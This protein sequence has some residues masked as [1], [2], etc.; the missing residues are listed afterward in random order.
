MVHIQIFGF[1]RFWG[2][3]VPSHEHIVISKIGPFAYTERCKER[4]KLSDDWV[5]GWID[6]REEGGDESIVDQ[7]TR[8][9]FRRTVD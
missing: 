4:Q 8:I 7:S 3:F 2:R 1:C 5:N 6:V 9:W